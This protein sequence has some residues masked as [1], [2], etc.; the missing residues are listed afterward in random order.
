MLH[1]ANGGLASLHQSEISKRDREILVKKERLVAL[2]S[3]FQ[4]VRREMT[5][6]RDLQYEFDVLK[7]KYSEL[8]LLYN[9][10]MSMKL[11]LMQDHDTMKNQSNR[12]LLII[13]KLKNDLNEMK[14]EFD[15]SNNEFKKLQTENELRIK[16]LTEQV[17]T[18]ADWGF[19]IY[20]QLSK[21]KNKL[22]NIGNWENERHSLLTTIH[23]L[24]ETVRQYNEKQRI[25]NH[26]NE[27]LVV[28]L[29]SVK[30][31]LELERQFLPLMRVPPPHNNNAQTTTTTTTT[32][33]RK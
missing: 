15:K 7:S 5:S 23:S 12:D 26:R 31:D 9:K 28:K 18:S 3:E 22:A 30:R 14:N 32:S 2:E 8:Q 19:N 1:V 13:D 20:E 27:L 25:L 33:P 29:E 10:E 11:N 24:H 21:L 6:N 17:K 16:N 4:L